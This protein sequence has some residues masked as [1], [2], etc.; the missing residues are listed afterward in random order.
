MSLELRLGNQCNLKCLTC[1]SVSSSL[2]YNE[3]VDIVKKDILRDNELGWLEPIW[4]EEIKSVDNYNIDEW[5]ETETFYSNIRK[6][7]P[8][9]RR[10]YTTGGEP[11]LIKAN[12]KMLEMLLESRMKNKKSISPKFYIFHQKSKKCFPP[13]NF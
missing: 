1:W 2:V 13:R 11:T 12:Y 3:R 6:M 5:Y 7:A 9:L 10:L 4:K 8:N